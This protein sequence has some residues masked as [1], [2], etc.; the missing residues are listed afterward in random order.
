MFEEDKGVAR[1]LETFGGIM[2]GA[3]F[4]WLIFIE[5]PSAVVVSGFIGGGIGV[6]FAG[7]Y[8]EWVKQQI[9]TAV[10]ESIERVASDIRYWMAFV[11][12]AWLSL[13]FLSVVQK[14]RVND[15]LLSINENVGALRA[16]VKQMRA[17]FNCYVKPR[18]LKAEQI[19]AIAKY[20]SAHDPQEVTLKVVSNDNE[21]SEFSSDIGQALR[22]GGWTIVNSQ[23]DP[24]PCL[25]SN[26][27]N[28]GQIE[29]P[30][31]CLTPGS[32]VLCTQILANGNAEPTPIPLTCSRVA[33]KGLTPE[34]GTTPCAQWPCFAAKGI[35]NANFTWQQ[36]NYPILAQEG[37]MT[38]FVQTQAHAQAQSDPKHPDSLAL[39]TEAFR[40]ANVQSEGGGS[41]SGSN[42]TKD[43][44]SIMIGHRRR[45]GYGLGCPQT[46]IKEETVPASE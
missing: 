26:V 12:V 46:I 17:D 2:I 8:W 3:G 21:A 41:G 29:V 9:P 6:F 37:W 7:I 32:G 20:L 36:A 1:F 27:L 40:L 25:G 34:G 35:G 16:D 44:L 38:N 42:I 5:H 14:L 30:S 10:T 22:Q 19:S 43:S 23:L 24:N 28:A 18:R 31:Y 11:L 39:L 45:D 4:E 33:D 15:T 13:L